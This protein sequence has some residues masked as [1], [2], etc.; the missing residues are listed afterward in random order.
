M[1]KNNENN[2]KKEVSELAEKVRLKFA[3]SELSTD[4]LKL[5]LADSIVRSYT[6][7]EKGYK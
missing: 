2:R 1:M 7:E 5:L 4:D 6:L 3:K